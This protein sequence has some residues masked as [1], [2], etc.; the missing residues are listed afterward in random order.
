[1]SGSQ[2]PLFINP[3]MMPAGQMVGNGGMPG[4]ALASA[5]ARPT[6]MPQLSTPNAGIPLSSLADLM[7]GQPT[8]GNSNGQ[9]SIGAT[10]PPETLA[11][12][13]GSNMQLGQPGAP[14]GSGY[15]AALS[16][17]GLMDRIGS[18]LQNMRMGGGQ[19]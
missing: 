2:H 14:I 6:G 3:P 9:P 1:M 19:T 17:P 15:G 8:Y 16:Q 7:K 5:M 4:S 11:A 12:Q 10:A 13:M 18:W